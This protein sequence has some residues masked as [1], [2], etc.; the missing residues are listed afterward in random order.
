MTKK[1]TYIK[2]GIVALFL[3]VFQ[4]IQSQTV[5]NSLEDLLPYLDDDNANV[6]LAPG[7]YS[8]S[9]FDISNGKFGNPLFVFEGSNSTFDFTDVTINVNTFVFQKFG[10][11]DVKEIQILGNNNVLKNLTLADTGDFRPTKTAQNITIDGRDNRI[12]GFHVSSRGSYPYGYGDAFGKGAGPVIKHYKHSVILVRG[13]RNHVKNCTVISRTYGHCIFMQAA[14]Y[15]TIEGC[16]IEGEVRTTDDMLAEKSGPAFDVGF[17]TV[18]GYKLPAGYMMSLQEA[19]IRAY[20]SGT[21]YIDGVEIQ[22][23]TDNPTVL[24]CTMKNT[25]TG[26]TLAHA[27]G[28]SYVEGCIVQGCENGYSIGSG[29]IVNCGADAI[30]GPVYKNAYE[31]DRG[32]VADITVL[33]PSDAYYNGHDAIAYVGGY[34]HNL[35]F[36]SDETNIPSNLKIMMGGDLQGLR[37]LNGSNPS[38]NNHVTHD[39]TL[40]NF[41]NFPVVLDSKSYDNI[42]RGCDTNIVTDS[43]T[44]NSINSI[45]CDSDNLALTGIASQSTTDHGGS[46]NRA[47]DENTSGV[48]SNNS[49]T[50]TSVE[51][52]PWWQVELQSEV[53]I[54]D[55]NVFGRTDSCCKER[56]SNFTVFVI[57]ANANTTFSQT[58]TSFPDP[59]ITV[60]A[61]GVLGKIVKIVLNDTLGLSLAEVE[62][63]E[64][65]LSVNDV[66]SHPISFYP[67]PVLDNLTL[68]IGQAN[69]NTNDAKIILYNISGQIV[70]E[71]RPENANEITLDLS[72][73]N[74]GLYLLRVSDSNV[75]FTKKV[76]KL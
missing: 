76:M 29:T 64:S 47:I 67:N 7:T 63:Y 41:T 74:S 40:T 18:W 69:L 66:V 4:N 70:L 37:V 61:G 56:L 43:G 60:N 38:Q 27:T 48:W 39:V 51:A 24:N 2:A 50:H 54:G 57:D 15:P 28:T 19:G 6:K 3:I 31:R 45:N 75:T 36:R 44:N 9:A 35:T 20:N 8:I 58:F 68:N 71:A 14:S 42:V 5:V 55:I 10:N 12:E 16:Y 32:Y 73:M 53:T 1:Y 11:V 72:K 23:G 49:V 59:L 21:T 62:V 46:A 65:S 22:R 52:N 17:M 30:Y 13:L 34:E 33:P 26:V 25:R